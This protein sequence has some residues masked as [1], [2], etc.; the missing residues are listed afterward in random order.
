MNIIVKTTAG[1][2]IV[3]PDTT[4]EK[5][6]ED[7]YPPEFIERLTYTPVLFARIC[8]PGRSISQKF[9]DRYYDG[10]NYGVLLYPED[11][12][13][14]S[15]TGFATASMVDHT[16]FLPFPLYGKA[17]LGQAENEFILSMKK[18]ADAEPAVLFRHNAATEQMIKE[19]I[20]EATSLIY[21]RTGDVIAIELDKRKPLLE[22]SE[23]SATV[24][25]TFCGN[26]LL[27][28]NIVIWAVR[29]IEVRMQ[30][31]G[32]IRKDKLKIDCLNIS[33]R[34]DASIHMSDIVILKTSQH[35]YYGIAFADVA[36]KSVAKSLS[37]A[38]ALDKTGYIDNFH[39]SGYYSARID[40]FGQS[41]ETFIRY[42]YGTD[43]WLNCT[44]R[45]I[46]SL[47]LGG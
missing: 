18:S 4:W 20:E 32:N 42:V 27:D 23:G 46:G 8:K 38:C 33:C 22:R 12:I 3:R 19:S 21:I 25:G 14:G 31:C 43:I 5:D 37:F 11:M 41:G 29:L 44:E 39:R 1:K 30:D 47:R 36:E 13:D 34:I 26:N 7:F 16:S 6:N 35:V 9:A 2:Y 24:S 45:E 10:I 40:Y 15:E 17:V 28:F